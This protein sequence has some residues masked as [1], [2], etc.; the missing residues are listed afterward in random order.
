MPQYF[1]YSSIN[2]NK[3]KTT[4]AISGVDGGPGGVRQPI[5]WGKKFALVDEQLVVQ[6]FINAL[7]IRKGTK[8]GNPGYGTTL[9]DFVFD[10]STLD[11]VQQ[12]QQEIRRVVNGDPRLVI[13][14]ISVYPKDNGILIEL[15]LAIQPFNQAQLLSVFLNQQSGSAGLQ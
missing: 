13:N 8:V 12:I 1:G 9:W 5:Y 3:P 2:A 7:N 6:D 11:V 14:T 15:E 4:N 10:P